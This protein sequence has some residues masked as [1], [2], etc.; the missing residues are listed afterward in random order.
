MT[1]QPR[2]QGYALIVAVMSM[3]LFAL[4]A[5]TMINATR[6]TVI[7]ASA[8]V[9][10]AQL[11]AG[12]DAGLAIAMQGLLTRDPAR[13]WSIAGQPRRIQFDD[14][15]LTITIED[16]RGKIALNLINKAQVEIMFAGFGLSGGEL[17]TAVDGF[18]DWRDEDF[19]PRLRGAEEDAY[20]KR[21][22]RPRNGPL[23]SIGELALIEGVGPGL[24]SRIA[25]F[26]TIN[27][28]SNGEFDPR[29]STPLAIRVSND[30]DAA[31]G[32]AELALGR[33]IKGDKVAIELGA[34]PSL[35]GRPLTISVEAARG[36]TAKLRRQIIVELTGAPVRPYVIRARE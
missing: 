15:V 19:T 26:A 8:E 6:G 27:F 13:R 32:S 21:R 5:L 2:E 36:T 7:M 4:M 12:A 16:E 23:R 11:S 22:I 33:A 31:S 29:F 25:P 30:S 18:L 35:I 14:M 24:A 34:T 10:R 20:Q 28:G 3:I 17:E 9:D 1:P